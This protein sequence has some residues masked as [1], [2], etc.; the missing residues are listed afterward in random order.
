MQIIPIPVENAVYQSQTTSHEQIGTRN[1][2][3][4][5]P[6][7]PGPDA[8]LGVQDPSQFIFGGTFTPATPW[9]T[10]FVAS[11]VRLARLPFG[12]DGDG[13]VPAAKSALYKAERITRDALEGCSSAVSPYLVPSGDGSVQVEWHEKEGELELMVDPLGRMVLWGRDHRTGVEFEGE[14][15]S[16]RDLFLRW[17]PWIA[18]TRGDGA[19]A[20]AQTSAVARAA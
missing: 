15:E 9:L 7:G 5:A 16:A 14:N 17:A 8:M 4:P 11:S 20:V 3:G 1:A 6:S 13:S 2:A 12:W 18:A 10:D 19:D